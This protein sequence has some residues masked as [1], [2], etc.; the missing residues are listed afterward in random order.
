MLVATTSRPL[1]ASAARRLQPRIFRLQVRSWSNS[2]PPPGDA[3]KNSATAAALSNTTSFLR[4]LDT[5]SEIFLVGTAHVSKRSA[6]E[7]REMITL[8]K[9]DVVMVELCPAQQRCRLPARRPGLPVRPRR[10]HGAA[11]VEV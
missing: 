11:N 5:G 9:P 6:Q 10:Q 4:N 2:G 7:V 3:T 8:V 1:A